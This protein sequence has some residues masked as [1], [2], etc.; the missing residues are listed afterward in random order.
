[1]YS[2]DIDLEPYVLYAGSGFICSC[3]Y[4]KW[5]P[6]AIWI[7]LIQLN[8]VNNWSDSETDPCHMKRM[9]SSFEGWNLTPVQLD[10]PRSFV[11]QSV[12]CI[13]LPPVKDTKQSMR[14]EKE[15]TLALSHLV[16]EYKDTR[17][18][19]SW[20]LDKPCD[21]HMAYFN[22]K[23]IKLWSS[24]FTVLHIKLRIIL[25]SSCFLSHTPYLALISQLRFIACYK[26]HSYT[27]PPC[28]PDGL[29]VG[30]LSSWPWN[31][32]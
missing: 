24:D 15:D 2:V 30:R 18:T 23:P 17:L 26:G 32:V 1:M 4:W 20:G 12:C 3:C 9:T 29:R 21:C 28:E 14:T 11:P 16:K 27:R 5:T 31:K 6:W 8:A 25:V 22:L 10:C 19:D 7:Q 13:W